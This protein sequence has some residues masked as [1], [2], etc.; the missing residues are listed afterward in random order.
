MNRSV[1][2][3]DVLGVP[4]DAT[5]SDIRA[6]FRRLTIKYHPDRFPGSERKDAETRF[7]QI[8]E[9]FN[10]LG[11][12]ASRDAYDRELSMTRTGPSSTGAPAAGEEAR[13]LTIKGA[14][15]F[16]DGDLVTA[17][18]ALERAVYLDDTSSKAHF[19]LGRTLLKIA[20]QQRAGL[21]HIDRA[22]Q[23]EPKDT[24]L[25]AQAAAY[26]LHAGMKL[27]A[28]RL[29]QEVLSQDPSNHRAAEVLAAAG[30]PDDDSDNGSLF[31]R[32]KRRNS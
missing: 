25:K 29:A 1:T 32:F 8:T 15:A 2:Y 22:V 23:L 17:R 4:E 28:R 20:G 16:K 11:H 19:F 9:A 6:A 18:E 3:Y 5:L 10:V 31:G 24:A 27:R 26:F 14:Q 30:D 7:Q 13:K 12:Q 21:R